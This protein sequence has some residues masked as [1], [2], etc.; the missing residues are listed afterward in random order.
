MAKQPSFQFYPGDWLKDPDLQRCP[1][2]AIGAYINLLCY[3]FECD[4]R[5]CLVSNGKPWSIETAA[6][7][8]KVKSKMVRCLVSQGVLKF[9]PRRG[10]LFS[11]RMVRDERLRRQKRRSGRFGGLA[12]SKQNASR[13]PSKTLAD[14]LAKR[15][16]SSSSSTS[17]KELG[18][19]SSTDPTPRARKADP[20][21]DTVAELWFKS[22]SKP[23]KD[24]AARIGRTVRELK[25]H[26]DCTPEEIRTR[27]LLMIQ[28]MPKGDTPESMVKHWGKFAGASGADWFDQLKDG[29]K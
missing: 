11:A 20:I 23:T 13:S 10:I 17:V 24:I 5:G 12:K 14:G 6:K 25:A 4:P 27:R 29:A 8:G 18:V 22:V 21:W 19:P 16:S 7:M 26:D 28:E 3:A 1:A 2:S 15:Y 9:S